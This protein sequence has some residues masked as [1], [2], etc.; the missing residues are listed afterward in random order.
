M[1]CILGQ[2]IRAESMGKTRG[3]Y[4]EDSDVPFLCR[5]ACYEIPEWV[6]LHKSLAD[7]PDAIS[8]RAKRHLQQ[9]VNDAL[10]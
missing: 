10:T 1:Q 9:L 4:A 6:R 5:A 7:L 3:V 8:A 2:T